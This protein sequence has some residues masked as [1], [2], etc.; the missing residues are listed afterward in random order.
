[1][2]T[3][4]GI[5]WDYE[6]LNGIG[7]DSETLLEPHGRWLYLITSAL[8]Y[9]KEDVNLHLDDGW[10]SESIFNQKDNII[11]LKDRSFRKINLIYSDTLSLSD[12][13]ERT[14]VKAVS[15]N[16]SLS[17]VKINKVKR[18]SKESAA[19]LLD[20]SR[21]IQTDSSGTPVIVE[22]VELSGSACLFD[23][24]LNN[25]AWNDSDFST[26]C[27]ANCPI[28]YNELRPFIPGE[29]EYRDAYVGFR[30]SIPPTS[31]RFGVANSSV[32]IDVEDT[33]E[34]GTTTALSGALTEVK[35]SKR[36]YTSPHIMTSLNYAVENCYIEVR[37]VSTDGFKFGLKSISTG[38][39]LNG[40]INWLADGY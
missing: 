19:Y 34:K 28:N 13:Y 11:T 8:N 33:V 21:Y 20:E 27:E 37:D 4:Y 10:K 23:F 5:E 12:N 38:Q 9:E 16:L 35:F 26:W 32:Y 36:F 18:V 40:E 25:T 31:G 14:V 30:L 7:Y 3:F 1:M 24:E 22:Q 17:D 15:D 39:Y 2:I 29:Y 6:N